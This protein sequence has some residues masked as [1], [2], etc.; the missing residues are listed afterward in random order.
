MVKRFMQRIKL[1]L[2]PM[3]IVGGMLVSAGFLAPVAGAAPVDVLKQCDAS[4]ANNDSQ[5]CAERK[6]NNNTLP[7]LLKNVINLLLIVIGIISVIMIVIGGFRY[8]TSAGDAGQTKSA[9]D[10]IIYAIVGLV[11]AIMSFALVNFVLNNLK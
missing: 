3:M 9:R 10:T 11:I 7:T 6:A 8:T 5:V 4:A 2:A 1:T